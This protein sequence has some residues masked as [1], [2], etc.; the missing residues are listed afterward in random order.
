MDMQSLNGLAA[1][2]LSFEIMKAAHTMLK[3]TEYAVFGTVLTHQTC[4][5]CGCVL[6][7]ETVHVP[8]VWGGL[9]CASPSQ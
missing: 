8:M 5:A 3:M 6:Q 4:H 1:F 2:K 7:Q 9:V